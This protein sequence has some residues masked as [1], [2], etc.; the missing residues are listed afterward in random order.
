MSSH[1]KASPR[2]QTQEST[3][4]YLRTLQAE[5]IV[6]ADPDDERHPELRRCSAASIEL[7]SPFVSQDALVHLSSIDLHPVQP[8]NPLP[9]LD[10][11]RANSDNDVLAVMSGDFHQDRHHYSNFDQAFQTER[12][13]YATINRSSTYEE[14][15]TNV[16]KVTRTKD[17]EITDEIGIGFVS[18][19][20][21]LSMDF[22]KG[23]N[24][25]NYGDRSGRKDVEI[26]KCDDRPRQ[27]QTVDED[28]KQLDGDYE[29]FSKT[30]ERAQ[31]QECHGLLHPCS[32]KC[33]GFASLERKRSLGTAIGFQPSL[34]PLQQHQRTKSILNSYLEEEAVAEEVQHAVAAD[35]VATVRRDSPIV[36][37]AVEAMSPESAKVVS[38]ENDEQNSDIVSQP[39]MYTYLDVLCERGGK[40]NNHPGNKVYLQQKE[41]MQDEYEMAS[42]EKKFQMSKVLVAF[43]HDRGGRFMKRAENGEWY[44]VDYKTARLKASQSLRDRTTE[45][46]LAKKKAVMTEA[47]E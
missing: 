39:S 30:S 19:F 33:P 16:D 32:E 45:K 1:G 40:G 28:I 20:G 18:S 44:E 4:N 34:M 17:R 6:L 15:A 25:Y 2:N 41:S 27:I 24:S 12:L 26:Q 8:P 23:G 21:T 7:P 22:I 43:I 13:L 14:L 5:T 47:K 11:Q 46:E 37:S 31:A 3:L 9:P 29:P 42:K 10:F 35:G 36:R 38:V